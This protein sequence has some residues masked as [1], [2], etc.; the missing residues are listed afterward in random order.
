MEQDARPGARVGGRPF[1][2]T[3]GAPA[4]ARE[5]SSSRWCSMASPTSCGCVSG[6]MCPA[7]ATVVTEPPDTV[8][9]TRHHRA[10]AMRSCSPRMT[11]TFV[12]ARSRARSVRCRRIWSMPRTKDTSPVLR[13]CGARTPTSHGR[14][15][16]AVTSQRETMRGQEAA[17]GSVVGPTRT[18]ACTR[19]LCAAS[20]TTTW[21]PAL[22][23]TRT[24]PPCGGRAAWSRRTCASTVR[25][26]TP[27][28]DRPMAGR[29]TTVLRTERW[30]HTPLQAR[31]SNPNPGTTTTPDPA[32]LAAGTSFDTVSPSAFR[33]H[34]CIPGARHA[35]PGNGG[36]RRLAG[37]FTA[38]DGLLPAR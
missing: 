14:S 2:P 3:A 1:S 5:P 8:A 23:P 27:C 28:A 13:Y 35:G 25:S 26:A 7:P 11:R 6:T 20:S 36:R 21:Q 18:S 30:G 33:R 38:L 31:A 19:E 29:V 4:P 10:G 24:R 32:A 37:P 34:R 12:D 15:C 17:T 16:R 9:R 22:C